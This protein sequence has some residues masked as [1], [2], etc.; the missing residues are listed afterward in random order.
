MFELWQDMSESRC[1][2]TRIDD[3]GVQNWE[4]EVYVDFVDKD[5]WAEYSV[6]RKTLYEIDPLYKFEEYQILDGTEEI[7][8]Y[9]AYNVL[10]LRSLYLPDSIHRIA[11]NAFSTPYFEIAPTQNKMWVELIIYVP[12]DAEHIVVLVRESGFEGAIFTYDN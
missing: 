7:E 3:F 8:E 10:N 12:N 11:L 2:T 9:V 6:N 1:N 4:Q 5:N